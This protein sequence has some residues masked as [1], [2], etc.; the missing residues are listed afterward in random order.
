M[1]VANKWS[2]KSWI[3]NPFRITPSQPSTH[4]TCGHQAKRAAS[5]RPPPDLA[6]NLTSSTSA[7]KKAS[8]EVKLCQVLIPFRCQTKSFSDLRSYVACV[9]DIL[10]CQVDRL[11]SRRATL[12][13]HVGKAGSD[14]L[15]AVSWC[16]ASWAS[17]ISLKRLP[18]AVVMHLCLKDPIEAKNIAVVDL[19]KD[20]G[21]TPSFVSFQRMLLFPCD[22]HM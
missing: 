22:I 21:F 14:D 3:D 10:S 6:S 20:S 4:C 13:E 1:M 16:V 7:N 18:M 2:K 12:K 11:G 17:C 15:R 9:A 8:Q 5:N 19:S